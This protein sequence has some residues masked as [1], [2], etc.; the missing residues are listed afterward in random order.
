M[1]KIITSRDYADMQAE[2]AYRAEQKALKAKVAKWSKKVEAD[3]TNIIARET[4]DRLA[5]ELE[6]L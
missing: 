2:A 4:R 6:A 1:K 3:P 5:A